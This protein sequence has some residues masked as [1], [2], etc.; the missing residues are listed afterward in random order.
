MFFQTSIGFSSKQH[1]F[2]S[3]FTNFNTFNTHGRAYLNHIP[4]LSYLYIVISRDSFLCSSEAMQKVK[5]NWIWFD[6][7]QVQ[8]SLQQRADWEA[9]KGVFKRELHL[10]VF[11]HICLAWIR[12]S[13]FKVEFS[14]EEIFVF[15]P[16]RC[17]LANELNLPE[18]TIKVIFSHFGCSRFYY[19]VNGNYVENTNVVS[20]TIRVS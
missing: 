5:V 20:D 13:R 1:P 12:R 2:V 4:W 16:K 10:Q 18:N 17:E 11:L 3:R 14:F 19:D 8:D 15:R 7:L 6:L 9:G